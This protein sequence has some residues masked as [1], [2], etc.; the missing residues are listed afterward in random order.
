M[1]VELIT[2]DG[3]NWFWHVQS[4]GNNEI[5]CHSQLY[6]D[7]ENAFKGIS[8]A[9]REFL[10]NEPIK[11]FNNSTKVGKEVEDALGDQGA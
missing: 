3:E 9:R 4:G 10:K 2:E 8:A 7:K 6:S 5:L 1:G 11:I